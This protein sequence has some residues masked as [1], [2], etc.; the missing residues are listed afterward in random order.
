MTR[1]IVPIVPIVSHH[2]CYRRRT[3]RHKYLAFLALFALPVFIFLLDALIRLF[4]VIYAVIN[5]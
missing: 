1:S 4:F 5:K 2:C 3:H